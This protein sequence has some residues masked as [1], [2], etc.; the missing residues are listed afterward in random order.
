MAAPKSAIEFISKEDWEKGTTGKILKWA[1]TIG[2][3]IVIIVELM[4]ILAFLSRFK[5]DRD[6]TDLSEKIKQQQAIVT[7]SA[8]FETQFRFLQKQLKTIQQLESQQLVAEEIL[9][10][11][12][13]YLPLDVELSDLR[14]NGVKVSLNATALSEVGLGTF[15]RNLKTSPMF[16]N[17][18]LSQVNADELGI[19]FGLSGELN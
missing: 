3:H 2:R 18:S 13:S 6:L 16:K 4:V 19:T 1:L 9:G 8:Q 11:M 10:E 7:S 17:L 5:F 15:L 14:V 12:A